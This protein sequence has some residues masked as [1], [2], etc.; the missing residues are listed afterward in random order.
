MTKINIKFI[1]LNMALV[2]LFVAGY[3]Q[4]SLAADPII[5]K[6]TQKK[7][8]TIEEPSINIKTLPNGLKIYYLKDEELPVLQM[9]TYFET[10][11]LYDKID[12]RGISSF[13]MSAWRSG[14]A[15]DLTP[16]KMDEELEFMASKIVPSAGADLSSM[17]VIC[18]QKVMPQ[19]LDI[20][21]K[22]L[23][24]PKF[25]S[26]RIE[27]I[28]K[29][30][31]DG[32]RSRNEEPMSILNREFMQ[33]LYGHKSVYAWTSTPETINK[34]TVAS[35]QKHYKKVIAP[36]HMLIAASSPLEF[37][38][39]VAMIEPYF[40]G[41]DHR[42]KKADYPKPIKKEWEKSIEFIHKTGNQSSIAMGHFGAK[43]F[44]KDK[45]KLIL[46]DE[47][48]G[49]STFGSKLGDRLRTDLGLVYSIRSSF[50]FGREFA[51]FRVMTQTKSESTIEAINEI[52]SILKDM[53]D[54]QNITQKALDYA[55]ERI[56]NRLVFEYDVPFNI[57]GSRLT[58]DYRGYPAG[59]LKIYQSEI[60]KVTLQD[61]KDVLKEYFFPD[62]LK[63]FI[64]GDK[65]KIVGLNELAGLVE[66]PLDKE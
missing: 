27:V 46:A 10:G 21:F 32:I 30:I 44:N 9:K 7:L 12:D 11:G 2:F 60:N 64:V 15:A 62:K 29:K 47:I 39:F 18:L 33:S 16:D 54:N 43:R 20:F 45:Y 25:D 48:L 36:N 14:G 66:V 41:W 13:F 42:V 53:V 3:N 24:D 31:L 55:K 38:E 50:G 40:K 56:V 22:I 51:P 26:N 52:K 34:I 35:L 1:C 57:V 19:T 6:L 61:V 63:I 37:N 59:Y 5:K 58:Y 49:G 17:L 4:S 23:K 8:P 28:R 65:T